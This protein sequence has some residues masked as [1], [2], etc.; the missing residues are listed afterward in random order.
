MAIDIL[1]KA[2]TICVL[3]KVGSLFAQFFVYKRWLRG[4][5]FFDFV[6]NGLKYVVDVVC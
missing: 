3:D 2:F 5:N 1:I 6:K 4:E